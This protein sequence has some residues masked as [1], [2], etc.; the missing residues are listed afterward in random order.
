MGASKL[1][2]LVVVLVLIIIGLG[3]WILLSG[4]PAVLDSIKGVGSSIPQP[5]ALPKG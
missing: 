2:W 5:P 1:W 4:N 3:A